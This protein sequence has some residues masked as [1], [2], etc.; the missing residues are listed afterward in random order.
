MPESPYDGKDIEQWGGITDTLIKLHPLKPDEIVEIVLKSWDDIFNSK[1]GSFQIG[2]EIFPAPQMLSF[3]LH[4][5]IAHNLGLKYPDLYKV[6]TEK[7]EKD[8]HSIKEPLHSIEIKASSHPNQIFANRS[9]TAISK[10]TKGQKWIFY[11]R[12]F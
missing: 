1:I 9:S 5:L 8:V 6:G 3:F 10:R 12:K 2:K 11:Y 4:E 7:S